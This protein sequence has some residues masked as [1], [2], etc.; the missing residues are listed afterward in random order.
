MSACVP[1]NITY[2]K[3]KD[4]TK[5]LVIE[6]WILLTSV[7][8]NITCF[9]ITS[10][11]P[12]SHFPS[13]KVWHPVNML[14]EFTIFCRFPHSL[15]FYLLSDRCFVST[16]TPSAEARAHVESISG[17]TSWHS[18]SLNPQSVNIVLVSEPLMYQSILYSVHKWKY[19]LCL[20][21]SSHVNGTYVTVC[22]DFVRKVTFQFFSFS[23]WN[24]NSRLRQ[25]LEAKSMQVTKQK[26]CLYSYSANLLDM[27]QRVGSTWEDAQ[28]RQ[29]RHLLLEDQSTKFWNL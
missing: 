21:Y 4:G 11:Y 15:L 18:Y 13:Q 16:A 5:W 29:Y 3:K 27:L 10:I 7:L 14:N 2:K 26:I 23:L 22:K 9:H 19:H 1:T 6:S 17:R 24:N 8:M 28:S 25:R 12:C 20:T